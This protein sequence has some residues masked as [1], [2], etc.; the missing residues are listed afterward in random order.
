M[1]QSILAV[2]AG[3]HLA[4]VWRNSKPRG[5]HVEFASHE[6]IHRPDSLK[7]HSVI[8]NFC[9]HPDLDRCEIAIAELPEVRLARQIAPT[10]CRLVQL[11]SRRVYAGTSSGRLSELSK[12]GPATPN[13]INKLNGET[14][15]LELLGDRASILRLA[16][17]FGL[18]LQHGRRTFMAR[19]LTGLRVDGRVTFDV[20]LSTARDF[21]PDRAFV[22]ILE[23]IASE[24]APGILNVGSGIPTPI[25]DIAA[26]TIEGFGGGSLANSSNEERDSFV[27]DVSRMTARYGN[28][29]SVADIKN[30]CYWLGTTTRNLT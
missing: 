20:A 27:L 9:R 26:W 11:S 22:R 14:A 3:S 24:P 2:G 15:V 7:S 28:A 23:R 12:V 25:G 21:L 19:V 4:S 10:N 29:C 18:E 6:A 8:I 5:V 13:G 17:V 16:N 30:Y 1:I